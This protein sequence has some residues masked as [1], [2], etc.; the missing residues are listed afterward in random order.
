M[1]QR[2]RLAI[3]PGKVTVALAR[4]RAAAFL[5]RPATRVTVALDPD[6]NIFLECAEAAQA[7]YLVTGNSRHFPERWGKRGY[8]LHGSLCMTAHWCQ[9]SLVS[10]RGDPALA[11]FGAKPTETSS[12]C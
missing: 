9:T 4:I 8:S 2:S 7:H 1:L 3:N 11:V 6:Q 5:V 12:L 10:L